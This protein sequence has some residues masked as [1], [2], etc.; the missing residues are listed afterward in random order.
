[1]I[2]LLAPAGG[3]DSI[4]AA[5]RCG[6]DAVYLGGE[7]FSA[8]ANAKNFSYEQL[9]E[10]VQYCHLHNVKVHQAVNTVVFDNELDKLVKTIKQSAEA[11]V[12]AV[13][14][15]DLGT[16]IL[17]KQL[18]PDMIMHASTQMSI[19]TKEGAF[20]AKELGFSRVVASRE[21]NINML[22]RN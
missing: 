7:S 19:H 12:D 11:G 15:Q 17:I 5:V 3:P 2:E 13:I 14:V 6:A 22:C 16:A 18:V 1:M 4:Q 10:A 21:L 8:R 9:C 20:F